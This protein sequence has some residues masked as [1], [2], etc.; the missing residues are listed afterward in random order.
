VYL[1]DD[2][3]TEQLEDSWEGIGYGYELY[4]PDGGWLYAPGHHRTQPL[5]HADLDIAT[6]N[7][8]KVDSTE[9][10]IYKLEIRPSLMKKLN[11]SD[12]LSSTR[13]LHSEV[14]HI[15]VKSENDIAVTIPAIHETEKVVELLGAFLSAGINSSRSSISPGLEGLRAEWPENILWPD[16]LL[17]FYDKEMRGAILELPD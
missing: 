10:I 2:P 13:R 7:R 12:F 8:Y 3:V 14:I 16:Y 9:G 4:R 5:M 11:V 6:H 15:I 17:S 1:K